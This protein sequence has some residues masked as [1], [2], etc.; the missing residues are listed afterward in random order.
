VLLGAVL[1]ALASGV[2]LSSRALAQGKNNDVLKIAA[3]IKK[4]D[5]EG[6]KAAAESLAKKVEE[7]EELMEV[8]KPRKKGGIGVGD[9]PGAITPDGIEQKLLALGRDA[10][11]PTA[12]GKEAA[13]LEEMAYAIAAVAEVT[14]AKAPKQNMGKKTVKDWNTWSDDMREAAVKLAEASKAKGAQDV[15]TAAS[16]LN[17]SCTNCHSVFR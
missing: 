17:A 12:L 6:A 7:M 11:S 15:K 16:K 4:G 14:K 2:Y 9:K 1:L 5:K 13:A 10:P 3:L 8:F